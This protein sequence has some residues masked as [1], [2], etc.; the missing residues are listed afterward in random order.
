LHPSCDEGE[1][2][3][4]YCALLFRTEMSDGWIP[5]AEFCASRF[6]G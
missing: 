1:T 2:I 4:R 6:L 5:R 3:I